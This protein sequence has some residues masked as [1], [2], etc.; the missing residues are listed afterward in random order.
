MPGLGADGLGRGL[1]GDVHSGSS[2]VTL[3]ENTE[4]PETVDVGDLL[5]QNANGKVS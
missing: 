4:G 2:R 1:G 5:V 3:L